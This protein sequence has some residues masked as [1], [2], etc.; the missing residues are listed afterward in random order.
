MELVTISEIS[1][2]LGVTARATRKRANREEWKATGAKVQG[3]GNTYN[4]KNLPK[5]I[6]VALAANRAAGD[7]LP[8]A[9]SPLPA[10]SDEALDASTIA[11]QSSPPPMTQYMAAKMKHK[12]ALLALY[13]RAL[14]AAGWG[15]KVKA[16]LEFEQAYNSGLAWPHL[17][18]QLGPVSWKTIESWSVKVR[19]HGNDCFHLADRRGAHLRGKCSLTEEQTEALLKHALVPGK[20]RIS[21]AIRLTR[22]T[23]KAMGSDTS[24]SD[25][26]MRR[27][28]LR[29]ISRNHDLW[30]MIREGRKAWSEQCEPYIICDYSK[31][32]VGDALVAD[33]HPLNFSIINPWT[34]KVQN[35]MTLLLWYDMASNMPLGWEIMPTENTAAISSALRRAILRLGMT[36]KMVYL[37][38]G[39]AFR[40]KYF[41]SLNNFEEI[42][43][44]GLY[45]RL[46]IEVSHAQ[47]YNAKAKPVERFFE[48]FGELERLLYP[49]Y[50]G[51][52]IENKPPRLHRGEK[53]HRQAHAK[54]FGEDCAITIEQA[55][56]AI[57]AWFDAYALRRQGPNSHLAGL[58][59]QDVFEAGRGPGVDPAE[60]HMLMMSVKIKSI[61]RSE[62]SFRGNV[63]RHKALYGRTHSVVIRY[64]LQ[65]PSTIYVFRPDGSFL[66]AAEQPDTVHKM[67]RLGTDE[68][69]RQLADQMGDKRGLERQTTVTARAILEQNV[70][71]EHRRQL[72]AIGALPAPA[73]VRP[74]DLSGRPKKN[75]PLTA[76]DRANALREAEESS[77]LQREMEATQL[78]TELDNMSETDRYDR[79]LEMEMR[80]EELNSEWR[81]FMRVYEQMPAFERD[82]DFWES[83]RVALAI[84]YGQKAAAA[85][86][87]AVEAEPCQEIS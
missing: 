65:D 33:G 26:T 50:T 15:N 72:E 78:I 46:G 69:R 18:G 22:S 42:G 17:F 85:G 36:P 44:E 40:A 66:C 35:H 53:M 60:L 49:I 56:M 37:D 25:A 3:G 59:P 27:W 82:R 12:A 67:A 70:L 61:R 19:R 87:T 84:L 43:F 79:L 86:E 38:N 76:E 64:D 81:R 80:G 20:R 14:A 57:A 54:M 4:L 16:R 32:V 5:A 75:V 73:G 31:L 1:L 47:P 68:D 48:T 9:S 21:E 51:T 41:K 71:P 30:V 10:E 45:G 63:Y 11:D 28:L 39:R 58:R 62:I 24:F 6:Q 2:A 83:R 77:R 8:L 34:G 23:L 7:L 74:T 52:S 55:H 13:N 29:W